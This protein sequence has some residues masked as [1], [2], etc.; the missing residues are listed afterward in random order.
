M[1]QAGGRVLINVCCP[2]CLTPCQQPWDSDFFVIRCQNEKC[3]YKYSNIVIER[4]T[5]VIISC[6]A[7]VGRDK[8]WEPI[9]LF[10]SWVDEN[11]TP[12]YPRKEEK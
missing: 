2:E 10:P 11:G 8:D 3:L 9:R 6:D 7:V 5:G 1:I 4:R 12:V